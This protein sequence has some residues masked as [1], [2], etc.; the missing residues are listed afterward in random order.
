MATLKVA[1]ILSLAL[2]GVSKALPQDEVVERNLDAETQTVTVTVTPALPPGVVVSVTYTRAIVTPTTLVTGLVN[3]TTSVVVLAPSP[4]ATTPAPPPSSR[5]AGSGKVDEETAD[6]VARQGDN[7]ATVTATATAPQPPANT[8]TSFV[9]VVVTAS[10]TRTVSRYQC[11][12]TV[13]V[14]YTVDSTTTVSYTQTAYNSTIT[15]TSLVTC[16]GFGGGFTTPPPAVVTTSPTLVPRQESSAPAPG[17]TTTAVL[18][19]EG[20]IATTTMHLTSTAYTVVR[21]TNTGYTVAVVYRCSPTVYETVTVPR[22][23]TAWPSTAT[24]VST[25]DCRRPPADMTAMDGPNAPGGNG[26]RQEPTAT[27]DPNAI[28]R[29]R[30]VFPTVTVTESVATTSLV[31]NCAP[32]TTSTTVSSATTALSTSAM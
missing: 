12:A 11:V 9:P 28:H 30:T 10:R 32:S 1:A 23:R 21:Q 25:V 18:T 5:T 16:G 15:A 24:V 14:S 7:T 19:P 8:V 13:A 6:L 3:C 4:T 2:Y 31:Y 17:P 29:T 20:T 22:T 26:R 27:S